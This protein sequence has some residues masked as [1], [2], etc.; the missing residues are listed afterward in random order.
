MGED[1]SGTVELINT[2]FLYIS[3]PYS[4]D[5]AGNLKN[6]KKLSPKIIFNCQC[7]SD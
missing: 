4:A 7:S 2:G 3:G 1:G 6:W 5:D